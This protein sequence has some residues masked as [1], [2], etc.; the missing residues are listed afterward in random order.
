MQALKYDLYELIALNDKNHDI[1]Y[2]FNG[3]KN[4]TQAPNT[5]PQRAQYLALGVCFCFPQEGHLTFLCEAFLCETLFNSE[6]T[7]PVGTAMMA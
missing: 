6:L 5:V 4:Y 3:S 1:F 2:I 7:I